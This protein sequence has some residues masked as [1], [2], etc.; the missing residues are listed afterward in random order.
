MVV[1]LAVGAMSVAWMAVVAAVV[2]QKLLP[3]Y[4]LLDVPLA[5]SLVALGVAVAAAPSSIPGII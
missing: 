3:P 1:L 5:A 2:A 4:A